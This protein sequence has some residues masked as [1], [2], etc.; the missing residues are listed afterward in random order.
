[1]RKILSGQIVIRGLLIALTVFIW[2][3][4]IPGQFYS[5]EVLFCYTRDMYGNK[6]LIKDDGAVFVEDIFVMEIP[7]DIRNQDENITVTVILE[8]ESGNRKTK[9]VRLYEK[10][11]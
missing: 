2:G 11:P 7:L 1:M 10:K 8:D 6:A 4:K 3:I 5:R 9:K